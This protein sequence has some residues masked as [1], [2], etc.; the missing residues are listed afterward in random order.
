MGVLLLTSMSRHSDDWSQLSH[1]RLTF[2]PNRAPYLKR[3]SNIV[4][5][6]NNIFPSA[7]LAGAIKPHRPVSANIFL[8]YDLA[9]RL[10]S[11]TDSPGL[12]ATQPFHPPG[13]Y[14]F[15]VLGTRC[16]KRDVNS[17]HFSGNDPTPHICYYT[18][19][20]PSSKFIETFFQVFSMP[21]SERLSCSHSLVYNT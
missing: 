20:H 19:T 9:R 2:F 13:N 17:E 6:E 16:W 7:H 18:S 12:F 14:T 15:F 11:P 10:I 1:R 21:S 5:N 4:D 8:F 3:F